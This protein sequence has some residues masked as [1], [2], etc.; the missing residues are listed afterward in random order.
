MSESMEPISTALQRR[1]EKRGEPEPDGQR[2]HEVGFTPGINIQPG[3]D[4]DGWSVPAPVTLNDGTR[5]QLYKDGE[6]L[7]A[8]VEAIQHA[9][10]RIFLE[11]Y[12]WPS[13]ET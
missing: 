6:G 1:R 12:I 13:D 3:A 10:K 7:A 9:R 4:D 11:V 2:Q 8:A 5:L